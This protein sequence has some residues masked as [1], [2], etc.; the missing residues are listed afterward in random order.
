[1]YKRFN[2]ILILLLSFLFQLSIST[3][4]GYEVGSSSMDS[5][6]Y[7]RRISYKKC[8]VNSEAKDLYRT[9]YWAIVRS[10]TTSNHSSNQTSSFIPFRRQLIVNNGEDRLITRASTNSANVNNTTTLGID[11]AAVDIIVDNQVRIKRIGRF[12]NNYV[13]FY[14]DFRQFNSICS[15]Y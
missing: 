9:T 8:P 11:Q 3:R 5:T 13:C 1:M 2:S 4:N 10:S 7:D 6:H 12:D 14:L 15:S